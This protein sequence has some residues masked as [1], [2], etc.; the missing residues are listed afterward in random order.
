MQSKKSLILLEKDYS[1]VLSREQK[2]NISQQSG[3]ESSR[4][5]HA[6]KRDLI[7]KRDFHPTILLFLSLCLIAGLEVPLLV[8]FYI[9][10][11][12]LSGL[13]S[14]L[15]YLHASTKIS[16]ITSCIVPTLCRVPC[17]QVPIHMP[18]PHNSFM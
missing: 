8:L 18:R 15:G 5:E 6:L 12:L 2:R 10:A 16:F 14:Y 3:R 17:F 13:E 11:L 4:L 1:L 7:I 9:T